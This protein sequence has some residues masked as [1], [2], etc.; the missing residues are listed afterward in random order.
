MRLNALAMC[1]IAL[2]VFVPAVQ[3]AD[4]E[5]VSLS[6]MQKKVIDIGLN[7]NNVVEVL[8]HLVNGIGARLTGSHQDH[9]ACE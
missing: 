1:F 7:D 8:D 6:E 4:G 2:F 3:A 9:L 5:V